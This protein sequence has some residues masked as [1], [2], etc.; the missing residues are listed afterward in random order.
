MQVDPIIL[1][2][3]A[4]GTKCLT[5]KR[6]EL[7]SSYTYCNLRRYTEGP[8]MVSAAP[9]LVIESDDLGKAVQAEPMKPVLQ[10]PMPGTVSA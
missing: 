5:L 9:V 7:L 4:P 6:D 2:L 3:K 10:A 8:G 1:T